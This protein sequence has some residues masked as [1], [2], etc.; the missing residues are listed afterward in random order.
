M[1]LRDFKH[2]RRRRW[3]SIQN[4]NL[5]SV[6]ASAGR[7]ALGVA[8]IEETLDAGREA[9][10][11][12]FGDLPASEWTD[13]LNDMIEACRNVSSMRTHRRRCLDVFLG[14][15]KPGVASHLSF[16]AS[17][18]KSTGTTKDFLRTAT[19][20]LTEAT[21]VWANDADLVLLH[22][23]VAASLCAVT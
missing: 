10:H 2:S 21:T 22:D 14:V 12:K 20:L 16:I 23:E 4:Q 7:V 13:A 5:V 19:G 1:E 17:Q 9:A 18:S 15:R 3:Q 8:E 11:R 6:V